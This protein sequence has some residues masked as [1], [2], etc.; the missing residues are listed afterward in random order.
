MYKD[1]KTFN[2]RRYSFLYYRHTKI[3]AQKEAKEE[4]KKGWNIR[5]VRRKIGGK[6]YYDL[7][8]RR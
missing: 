7:Y 4:R 8:G 5:I 2:G 1:T 6:T 3:E